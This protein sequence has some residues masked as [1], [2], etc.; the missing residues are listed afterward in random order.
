MTAGTWPT[1]HVEASFGGTPGSIY[2]QFND[3]V[4]GKFDT[5]TFGPSTA[6]QDITTDA[7]HI[8]IT[9][10]RTRPLIDFPPGT[11]EVTLDNSA[12]AGN[13]AYSP[14]NL[15]GPYVSAGVTE[16]LPMVK[17]R[18]RA[19]WS[20]TD[21]PLSYG[22]ADS[23]VESYQGPKY[24]EV[25]CHATDGFK[26]LQAFEPQG[27]QTPVGDSEDTGARLARILTNAGWNSTDRD[28]DTGNN[29]CQSTDLSQTALDEI[30]GVV[31]SEQGYCYMSADGKVTFRRRRS[32]L[33]DSRST[34]VQA[35]IDDGSSGVGGAVPYDD[36]VLEYDDTLIRN[37]V[38]G[39]RTGGL[40][41]QTSDSSSVGSFLTKSFNGVSL[42]HVNDVEVAS[43]CANEVYLH[44][45]AE[46]RVA[47]VVLKPL[48]SDSLWPVALGLK[49]GDL[50]KVVR[51]P[52]A[53]DAITRYVFVEGYDHDITPGPVPDW[54]TN[55]YFSS[56][57]VF[58]SGL[59]TWMQ[60][61][62]GKFDTNKFAPL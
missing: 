32:R 48:T 14:N 19:T 22:F 8:R 17:I 57:T 58:Q 28:L 35:T 15:S 21:Y 27:P 31:G 4:R 36:I 23:W 41:Q 54:T 34:S 43:W 47:S 46:E 20:G 24:Q 39:T 42:W 59:G 61:D 33:E 7:R 25:V 37:T 1:M 12:T 5:G 60:F 18:V 26:V 40:L 55:I 16:I 38:S 10:G 56:A 52:A 2:L 51:T 3:S 62:T 11:L 13:G 45:D 49:V 30:Y 6:F 44:K 29:L 50:V 53:G 9:G